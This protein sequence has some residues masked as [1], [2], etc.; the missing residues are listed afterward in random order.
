MPPHPCSELVIVVIAATAWTHGNMVVMV[1]VFY[2]AD[3]ECNAGKKDG[4]VGKWE[5][6]EEMK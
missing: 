3:H 6:C 1:V 2:L 4:G 5:E